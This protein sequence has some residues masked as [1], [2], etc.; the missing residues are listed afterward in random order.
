MTLAPLA[1]GPVLTV[2][3][4]IRNREAVPGRIAFLASPTALART[5][6]ERLVDRYGDCPPAKATVVVALGGDGFMLETLHKHMKRR[7]PI[8][9]MHR[10]SVGFL[11]NG[12][13]PDGLEERVAR[14]KPVRV[15]P[16]EMTVRDASGNLMH[17]VWAAL[18]PT[19]LS[20]AKW[21]KLANALTWTSMSAGSGADMW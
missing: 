10:G 4:G 11:M 7:V 14:A 21:L 15:H 13:S 1:A 6:R 12:Y 16:L 5:T 2:T 3:A 9:G 8:Y 20:D 17:S 18:A 19:A